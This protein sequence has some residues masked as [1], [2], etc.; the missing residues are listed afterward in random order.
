[1]R[2]KWRD[3]EGGAC[4]SQTRGW[5]LAQCPLFNPI[6]SNPQ[7]PYAAHANNRCTARTAPTPRARRRRCAPPP[8]WR[9]ACSSGRCCGRSSRRGCCGVSECV[10]LSD[11]PLLD[12]LPY[13]SAACNTVPAFS[14]AGRTSHPRTQ[15]LYII[16]L[17]HL[18]S[19]LPPPRHRHHQSWARG[20]SARGCRSSSPTCS[21]APP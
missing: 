15:P 9:R 12:C 5:R 8:R 19:S 14:P 13:S 2:K 1:M 4:A 16:T 6:R 20:R 7:T 17:H 3:G 21:P 11:A 18:T 10:A